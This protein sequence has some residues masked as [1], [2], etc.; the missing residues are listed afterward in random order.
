[1]AFAEDIQE[2]RETVRKHG[3]KLINEETTKQALIL[4][5]IEAWG[6]DT[7][8]PSEVMAE[9]SVKLSTGSSGRADYVIF[10][11][12]KPAIVIECKSA[13]VAF[14]ADVLEQL[15]EYVTASGATAGVFTDGIRYSCYVDS[16]RPGQMD[17]TPY[18]QVDLTRLTDDDE[19]ALSLLSKQLFSPAR[20]RTSAKPLKQRLDDMID[21]DST[22]GSPPLRDHIFRVGRIKN[23]AKRDSDTEA[24]TSRVSDRIRFLIESIADGALT[25]DDSVVTTHEELDTFLLVKGMLHDSIE[26]HRITPRDARSYFSVFVDDNNRKPIC[27]FHFNRRDKYIGTFDE[28]KQETRHPMQDLSDL[29]R[30]APQLKRAAKRYR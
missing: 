8:N 10:Y 12:E 25:D 16:E 29:F 19:H 13:G 18:C 9:H 1:M 7:R 17:H 21:I 4:P 3:E 14:P 28:N 27:R 30:L 22:L 23:R 5:M 2:I 15:R 24:L 26:P 20:L 11:Q 6:Y